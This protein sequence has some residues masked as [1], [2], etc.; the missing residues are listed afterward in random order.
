[1]NPVTA[2]SKG[3]LNQ[4][5]QGLQST[6]NATQQKDQLP[7]HFITAEEETEDYFP[8][9]NIPN[10][11]TYN[12]FAM[13]TTFTKGELAYADLTGR[14]PVQSSRGNQYLYIVYDYDGNAILA[15]PIPNRQAATIKNAWTK[16][17]NQLAYEG[18]E[19]QMYI[20]DNEFSNDLRNALTKYKI[21]FQLAPPH[22]HRRNAVERA[23]QTFKHHFLAGLASCND[24]FPVREWDRLVPQAQL[25]LN[26]LR[27]SRLKPKLS[28]HAYLFGVYDYNA[29]PLA[30]PGVRVVAHVKPEVRSSWGF[31][32]LDGWTIGASR[33]HYRCLRVFIPETNAEIDCDTL[34]FFPHSTPIPKF[35]L[36]EYLKQAT[37]DL[38]ILLKTKLKKKNP[39]HKINFNIQAGDETYNALYTLATILNRT[40]PPPE[41]LAPFPTIQP[42]K[43]SRV[44]PDSQSPS[45]PRVPTDSPTTTP[46]L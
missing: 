35:T 17:N 3:H 37:E 28:A 4:E 7:P 26:L 36:D 30:P 38:I 39:L 34:D 19:P 10:K 13:I 46:T 5:R 40:K 8:T 11:K 20:F 18:N 23:I 22:I 9:R 27:N 29:Y 24:E 12:C 44:P 1:M 14:F 31:H 41:L 45:P 43:L 15:E 6:K 2:T 42:S 25:T 32:G 33:D 21:K 16:I